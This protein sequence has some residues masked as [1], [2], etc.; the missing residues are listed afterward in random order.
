M[1]RKYS[2]INE[3]IIRIKSLFNDGRLYGNLVN[4]QTSNNEVPTELKKC[5]EVEDFILRKK[6]DNKW[7]NEKVTGLVKVCSDGNAT[8][9]WVSRNGK[10]DGLY[11]EWNGQN[12]QLKLESNYKDGKLDGLWRQWYW[13]GKLAREW[14]YKDGKKDGLL[15]DW[16]DNG[17][18][19][20]ES[21]YKADNYD[22]LS[23]NWH[24]N[25]Q[26]ERERNFK[27]GKLDGLS[28]GYFEN[29]QLRWEE[30]H[31][32]GKLDGLQRDW[33]ENGKLKS[34]YNYKDGK[35]V[36]DVTDYDSETDTGAETDI[37]VLDFDS[38]TAIAA[39]GYVQN[40]PE[41]G[42]YETAEG[43]DG[44]LVYK[45]KTGE[46]EG[47]GVD[48]EMV[49]DD[50]EQD[51]MYTSSKLK[52]V[53]NIGKMVYDKNKKEFKIKSKYSL[54]SKRTGKV[55][56]KM[57]ESFWN[58]LSKWYNKP[59]N[60]ENADLQIKNDKKFTVSVWK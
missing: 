10:Y 33:Y 53:F 8:I 19:S 6:W 15:I 1:K 16:W 20:G 55:T 43:S 32:D 27:D 7:I 37:T 24:K 60:N 35:E 38:K 12:G 31:T 40:K 22:G 39:H 34:E 49:N 50:N 21:N 30:N 51:I 18:L 5:D 4:E 56:K 26:L 36:T 28:R 41:D 13:N 58:T 48:I 2:T 17:Q 59:L 14:N 45:V 3:E 23:R 11:R 57:E 44:V 52:K 54:L 29:G 42:E 46:V 47:G 25:G 9:V